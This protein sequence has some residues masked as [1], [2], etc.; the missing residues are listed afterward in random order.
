MMGF[1]NVDE[2]YQRTLEAFSISSD[3]HL[4]NIDVLEQLFH[5]LLDFNSTKKET[6]SF[7]YIRF[8]NNFYVLNIDSIE[9][10][11]F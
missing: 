4:T 8:F 1:E 2:G 7:H 5:I 6:L 11:D 10:I 3:I 9:L